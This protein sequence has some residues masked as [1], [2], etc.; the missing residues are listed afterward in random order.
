MTWPVKDAKYWLHGGVHASL[1]Y[2]MQDSSCH[3]HGALDCCS[4]KHLTMLDLL[5]SAGRSHLR[6][7][8]ANRL[9]EP[10]WHSKMAISDGSNLHKF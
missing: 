3:E 8:H 6:L 10:G 9:D 1:E 2:E 7:R 4:E 5:A